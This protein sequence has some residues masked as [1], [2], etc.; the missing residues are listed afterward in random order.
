MKSATHLRDSLA[1]RLHGTTT[2]FAPLVASLV[3]IGLLSLIFTL[4]AWLGWPGAQVDC[5]DGMCFCELPRQGMIRQPSNTWSNLAPLVL[6]LAVALIGRTGLRIEA[7]AAPLSTALAVAFPVALAWQGV[8]SALYHA[9]LVQ[10]AAALDA[11]SMF[12]TVTLLLLSNLARGSVLNARSV[13]ILWVLSSAL[14]VAV[15]HYLPLVVSPLMF[16]LFISVMAS[17]VWLTRKGLSPSAAWFRVGLATFVVGVGVWTFSV[18]DGQGLCA[19]SSPLQAHALWHVTSALAIA[20]FARHV[21]VNLSV[22]GNS[23]ARRP[24]VDA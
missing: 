24:S 12:T 16:S 4:G 23:R 6:S 8:G 11:M 10:W 15:G 14:G 7:R 3:A 2:R 20:A 13:A 18:I 22:S 21:Q 9:S 5:L 17:E 19:P 1:P